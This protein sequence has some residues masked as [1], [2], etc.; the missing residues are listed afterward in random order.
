MK[1]KKAGIAAVAICA[2]AALST[3]GMG[4]AKWQTNI[5]AIGNVSANGSWKVEISEATV[6][7]S[8]GSKA[9]KEVS[10]WELQRT[11]MKS[12][13][14]IAGVISGSQ[15]KDPSLYG[16]QCDKP[17]SKYTYYYLIDATKYDLSVEG[18]K[19]LTKEKA[20]EITGDESTIDISGYI[21]MYYSTT[22]DKIVNGLLRDC[23]ALVKELKPDTYKNYT[24]AYISKSLPN[25]QTAT[26]GTMTEVKSTQTEEGE[27]ING[28]ISDDKSTATF[29]DV[30]LGLPGSWAE[31]TVTVSNNG[32][33]DANLASADISFNTDST[34][35]ILDKPELSDETLKP[36]ETCT[37]TAVVKVPD[38]ITEDLNADAS[39]TISLP[40][41]QTVVE[42]APTAGHTNG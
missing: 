41:T 38:T 26:F 18:I 29:S 17:M 12:D 27:K 2:V 14:Y 20:E 42:E 4:F 40:Y 33:A 5:S 19:A 28:R 1:L 10:D 34:Q 36:G 6:N 30:T 11:N 25:T 13:A 15:T 3:I 22:A 21:N 31:Y 8:T 23:T 39:L 35:L 32:T 16:T 37:I 24:L 7:L 9:D